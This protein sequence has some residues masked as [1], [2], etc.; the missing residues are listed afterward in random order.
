MTRYSKLLSAVGK[1]GRQGAWRGETSYFPG[2]C[3]FILQLPLSPSPF[4]PF[5]PS[6]VLASPSLLP[7]LCSLPA[8]APT[9]DSRVGGAEQALVSPSRS[10]WV[11]RQGISC[12]PGPPDPPKR[13]SQLFPP[14]HQRKQ[15]LQS[16]CFYMAG[17]VID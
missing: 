7:G 3:L 6:P 8:P 2:H 16:L 1:A 15:T 14:P 12:H 10:P 4:P 17:H 9:A 11:G 13:I 5:L